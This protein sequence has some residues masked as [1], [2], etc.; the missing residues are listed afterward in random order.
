[1]A[2]ATELE[3]EAMKS[4]VLAL[5]AQLE[6][7][8]QQAAAAEQ[9]AH[10]A[11][12]DE[13]G[14]LRATIT[15]LRNEMVR[16]REE[17]LAKLRAAEREGATEAEHLRGAIVAARHHADDLQRRH[18]LAL[19][20]QTQQFAIERRELQATITELRRRLENTTEDDRR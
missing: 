17:L 14:Q 10:A 19:A 12:E 15:E 1:M 6:A 13:V 2:D 4:D 8:W 7:A 11:R 20:E 16:Q 5:R 18:E 3:R 9:R